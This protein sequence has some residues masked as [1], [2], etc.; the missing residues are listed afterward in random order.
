MNAATPTAAPY[1][2]DIFVTWRILGPRT[3]E[4]APR[5]PLG[6]VATDAV[7][8][9]GLVDGADAWTEDADLVGYHYGEITDGT[10]A[11]R[12]DLPAG[13]PPLP[14]GPNAT[15]DAKLADPAPDDEFAATVSMFVAHGRG[16]LTEARGATPDA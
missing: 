3:T 4:G 5:E 8:A 9:F 10:V 11:V 7:R 1:T 13:L 12:A 15:P 2:S 6:W 16:K 14:I